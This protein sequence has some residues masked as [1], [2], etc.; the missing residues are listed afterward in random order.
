M[1]GQEKSARVLREVTPLKEKD[2][3]YIADRRKKVFDYPI[4]VQDVFELNF[5]EHAPGVRR[6]VGDSS[7]VIGEYD[8]VI[9]TDTEL[10]HVW[11]QNTCTSDDIH[12]ITLQ[13]RLDLSDDSMLAKNPMESIR[14]ML[15]MARK[16]LCFPMNAIMR[17]YSLLT[18]L[19]EQKDGFSSFVQFLEILNILSKCDG[20]RTL[21]TSSYVKVN[22]DEDTS[23]ISKV[24][25]Y[26]RNNYR[27][28]IKLETLSGIAC[29]SE[30]AFSRYFK[31]HTGRTVSD[32]IIDTR[33]GF[34]ARMLVDTQETVA[35]I[36]FQC[37]YNNLSNFNRVF[38][39]K[40]GCT[41]S[42]FREYYRKTKI[43]V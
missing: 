12:E 37:G 4:H 27:D 32:Y 39:R 35:D 18:T 3:L 14:R 8:L 16:G 11:L 23:R 20:A 6:V 41:P 42:E 34:A 26:I 31:Q 38:K 9:I 1:K 10:E 5:V 36:S 33:L 15:I 22:T 40:K 29:M 43:I 25:D 21:A 28:E 2:V 19:S 7:E 17:V 13:F 30:A 24:K